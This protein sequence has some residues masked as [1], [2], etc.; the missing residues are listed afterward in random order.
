MLN[1]QR[2][3]KCPWC[4]QRRNIDNIEME[5]VAMVVSDGGFYRG[6]RERLRKQHIAA[7][8]DLAALETK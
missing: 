2:P 5:I 8:A 4:N 7:V 1:D 6:D 3:C